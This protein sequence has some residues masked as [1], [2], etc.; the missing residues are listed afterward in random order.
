MLDS[1]E[2]QGIAPERVK[3]ETMDLSK[4]NTREWPEKI[5]WTLMQ[6]CFCSGFDKVVLEMFVGEI[7]T[8]N[9]E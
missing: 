1:H 4:T 8:K 5:A 7:F 9:S 6:S 2:Y 3:A